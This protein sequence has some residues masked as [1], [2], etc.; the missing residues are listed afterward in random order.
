MK[1]IWWIGLVIVGS[2]LVGCAGEV[3]SLK[4]DAD[5]T[6][7]KAVLAQTGILAVTLVAN[8]STGYGWSVISVDDSILAQQGDPVFTQTDQKNAVGSWGTETLRFKGKALGKTTLVLGYRRAWQKDEVP[9]RMFQVEIEV[10]P[11]AK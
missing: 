1:W 10:V 3:D 7:G 9:I 5:S 11:A 8:P 4:L 2:F 6:G